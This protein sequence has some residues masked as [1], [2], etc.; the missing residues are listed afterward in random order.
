MGRKFC[1]GIG[2]HA[3][4]PASISRAEQQGEGERKR[5]TSLVCWGWS[6]LVSWDGEDQ[7]LDGARCLLKKLFSVQTTS[8][9]FSSIFP[10]ALRSRVAPGLSP[11]APASQVRYLVCC[12]SVW[13]CGSL[14]WLGIPGQ[15]GRA[16]ALTV[17]NGRSLETWT[18]W[19]GPSQKVGWHKNRPQAWPITMERIRIHGMISRQ[20]CRAIERVHVWKGW[21]EVWIV[22]LSVTGWR[23][24]YI[25][26]Y[27]NRPLYISCPVQLSK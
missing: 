13:A 14:G 2:H 3:V 21:D 22:P 15:T 16:S 11:G 17:W 6:G 20:H 23:T 9:I 18:K 19:D 5:E 7:G 27:I 12:L 24:P 1:S 26:T 10:G 25:S 4:C 8:S